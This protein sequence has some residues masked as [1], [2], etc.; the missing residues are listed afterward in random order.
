MGPNGLRIELQFLGQYLSRQLTQQENVSAPVKSIYVSPEA[1]AGPWVPAGD[2]FP[3]FTRKNTFH[4]WEPIR[5]G[6]W[7]APG[8][9]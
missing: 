9:T 4:P 5:S 1:P 3:R 6:P 7:W 2:V 8:L